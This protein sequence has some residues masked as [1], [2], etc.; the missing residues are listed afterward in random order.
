M[1]EHTAEPT[2]TEVVAGSTGDRILAALVDVILEGGLP[3]FSMQ[4]VADRAGVA[5]RTVYRHFPTREAL[6]DAIGEA[7]NRRMIERGGVSAPNG[8]G[9]LPHCVLINFRLFSMDARA[10]E[11]GVRFGVGAAIETRDR[12]ERTDRFRE[13]VAEGMP[14]LAPV[15][16]EMVGALLRQMAS[17]RSWL[18]LREIGLDAEGAARVSAWGVAV[19]IDALRAGRTPRGE[20]LPGPGVSGDT[21]PRP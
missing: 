17:S 19:L 8:L 9:D 15:D 5:H 12:R 10:M 20:S 21:S 2:E 13:V 1:S 14:D 4:E 6:L 7:V 16:V 11:A 18:G 3:D